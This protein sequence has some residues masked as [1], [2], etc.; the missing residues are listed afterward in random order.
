[1]K[2]KLVF[3]GLLASLF[4]TAGCKTTQAVKAHPLKPVY[5]E[6]VD[7]QGYNVV[8]VQPFQIMSAKPEDAEAGVTLANA[9]AKRLEYD[10]GGLFQ[11]VRVGEPTGAP[12]E[13]VVAGRIT[14]YKP[15]SRTARLLGPGIGRAVLK[16]ELQV[17]DAATGRPLEI[18]P[19]DKLWAWGHSIGAL[20]GMN[21]MMEE[22]AASAA[23]MIARA[24][25]WQP[26]DSSLAAQ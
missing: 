12:D 24:K 2:L 15:G 25:G 26:R 8:T 11:R 17:N 18:A 14:E 3:L 16:G 20:K 22:T 9:I 19:I 1:M 13:L 21:D 6:G 7:L 23:N 4:M 10:F 5:G